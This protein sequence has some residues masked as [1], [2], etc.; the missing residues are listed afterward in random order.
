MAGGVQAISPLRDS[1]RSIPT[2]VLGSAASDK[3]VILPME[4]IEL[5]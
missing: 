2:A 3:P 4:A 1:R 5:D